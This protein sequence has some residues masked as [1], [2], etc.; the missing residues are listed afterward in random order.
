[1]PHRACTSFV[2]TL[3]EMKLNR[4]RTKQITPDYRNCSGSFILCGSV[5]RSKKATHLFAAI[6]SNDIKAVAALCAAGVVDVDQHEKIV[7]R[8]QPKRGEHYRKQT[9]N[10]ETPLA[11]ACC[12]GHTDIVRILLGYCVHTSNITACGKSAL[13]HCLDF[14]YHWDRYDEREGVFKLVVDPLSIECAQALAE[15][16]VDLEATCRAKEQTLPAA[17][18]TAATDSNN[19]SDTDEDIEDG[20]VNRS[21]KADETVLLRSLHIYERSR[22]FPL[23]ALLMRQ[24]VSNATG[25]VPCEFMGY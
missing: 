1:M 21:W 22:D 16:G 4:C 13:M 14:S 6:L 8:W 9:L 19:A 11:L 20:R 10:S 25:T 3:R 7:L 15:A 12:L 2:F 24:G 5:R 17:L 18:I 23:A